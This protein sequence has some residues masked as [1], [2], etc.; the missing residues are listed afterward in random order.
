[1]R[2]FLKFGGPYW[3]VDTA[4]H[5]RSV[6]QTRKLH[7]NQESL[8]VSTQKSDIGKFL[9]V[10]SKSNHILNCGSHMHTSILA[11]PLASCVAVCRVAPRESRDPTVET[12]HHNQQM[13][14]ATSDGPRGR[15]RTRRTLSRIYRRCAAEPEALCPD[16]RQPLKSI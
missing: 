7:K 2:A 11:L 12:R 13:L 15:A 5:C 4:M 16:A 3:C 9:N 6:A 1:M 14:P 10:R 8:S